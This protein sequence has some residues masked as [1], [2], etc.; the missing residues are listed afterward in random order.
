MVK[1]QRQSLGLSQ[2]A[3]ADALGVSQRYVSKIEAGEC[4]NPTLDTIRSFAPI[5]N[6]DVLELVRRLD[7]AE[8]T[9]A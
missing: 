7:G 9:A 8:G 4:E 6:L 1:S 5:L 2:A 3:L